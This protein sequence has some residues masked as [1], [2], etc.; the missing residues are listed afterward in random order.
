[1][2]CPEWADL[3]VWEFIKFVSFKDLRAIDTCQHWEA[4]MEAR[5]QMIAEQKQNPTA[6]SRWPWVGV[7][8]V[9]ALLWPWVQPYVLETIVRKEKKK[10]RPLMLPKISHFR[11]SP[12]IKQKHL[13]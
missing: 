5:V 11:D 10:K 13:K 4:A 3:Q 9:I 1:M 8:V 6:A 2:T 7:R 12:K